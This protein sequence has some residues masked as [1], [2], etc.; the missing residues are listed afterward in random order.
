MDIQ[1]RQ[2]YFPRIIGKGDHARR[3]ADL[4]L[5][6]RKELDAE[7]SSGLAELS[8]RGLLPSESTESLIIIDREVDFGTPLLTQLTYEGL[9]DEFVGIKNNQAEVDTTIVGTNSAP[10]VQESSK[11]PQ[12]SLK[13]GQKR[14]I[15]LDSSDQLFSQLRDAN[16]AIVGDILNKVARERL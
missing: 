15:Q 11:A 10:Q 16:F 1:Q 3:L 9:I 12:Q 8:A 2:G 13:Q 4:L 7:E 14:K 6:M 5:R